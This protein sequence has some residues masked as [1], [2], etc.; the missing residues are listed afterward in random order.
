MK[1]S[2][3]SEANQNDIIIGRGIDADIKI[4]DI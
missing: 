3:F 4:N 1:N 2:L